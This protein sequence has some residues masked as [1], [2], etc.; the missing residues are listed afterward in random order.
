MDYTNQALKVLTR[1]LNNLTDQMELLLKKLMAEK[2]KE[3][4]LNI[5]GG[6][7][8]HNNHLCRPEK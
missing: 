2:K 8:N 7:I 4:H 6:E 3:S 1:D 5:V